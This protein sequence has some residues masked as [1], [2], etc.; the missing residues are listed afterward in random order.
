MQFVKPS[1]ET[2]PDSL[3]NA[4][5]SRFIEDISQESIRRDFVSFQA[6]FLVKKVLGLVECSNVGFKTQYDALVIKMEIV[7]C[8]FII[9]SFIGLETITSFVIIITQ[10]KA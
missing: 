10:V 3:I 2:H 8:E 7:G 9:P 1:G 5:G 4:H 6:F